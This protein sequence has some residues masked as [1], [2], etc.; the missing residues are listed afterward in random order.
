MRYK[1]EQCY[2]SE[3]EKAEVPLTSPDDKIKKESLTPN[4]R[5]CLHPKHEHF[6][7]VF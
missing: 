5:W 1:T 3:K 2:F 4:Q 6:P 7:E